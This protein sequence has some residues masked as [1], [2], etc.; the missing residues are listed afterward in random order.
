MIYVRYFFLT[1]TCFS[2]SRRKG[3]DRSHRKSSL[4]SH[5][6]NIICF[7]HALT[8]TNISIYYKIPKKCFELSKIPG[9]TLIKERLHEICTVKWRWKIDV[10][11][12]LMSNF[13]IK[14]IKI[15]YILLTMVDR[16]NFV[17]KT[18]TKYFK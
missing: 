18:A 15:Y 10:F 2:N 5:H 3:M 1:Q 6:F 7:S 8:S 13:F 16:N 17:E 4:A 9:N 12:K 14:K 11:P